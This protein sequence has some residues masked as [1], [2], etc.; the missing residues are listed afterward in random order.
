[1]LD[2]YTGNHVCYIANVTSGGTAVYGKDGSILR[3]NTV[4]IGTTAQPNYYL[5]VWNSSAGTM[6][7]SQ[8]GTGYW[9][10]RPA[11]GTLVEREG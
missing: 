1:M 4:N 8:D 2:A 10:W 7:S 3:Y 5:Q 11:G 9:Q 6:V